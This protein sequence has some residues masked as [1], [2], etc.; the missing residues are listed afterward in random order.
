MSIIKRPSWDETHMMDAILSATRSSC[1]IRAVGASLVRD[2]RVIA[3]GYN[4][5]PSKIKSCLETGECFYQRIAW[6]DHKKGLGDYEELKESRKFLCIASHGEVNA[7]SQCTKYGPSSV[8]SVLYITNL[9][10]PSCTRNEIL[11]KGVI[12]VKVWKGYLS[13][14]LLTLDEKRATEALL[15]EAGVPL[16]YVT[17]T[18]KRMK[19]IFALMLSVGERSSY[20]FNPDK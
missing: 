6:E 13:N 14:N 1:L 16:S 4:G 8:G 5:A 3:S 20:K 7:L 18:E 12:G 11:A 15:L 10:C 17:L 2:N 19:E 9:P